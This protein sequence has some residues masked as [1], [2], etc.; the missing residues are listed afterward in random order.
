MIITFALPGHL[1]SRQ[2]TNTYAIYDQ[3]VKVL[4]LLAQND[5]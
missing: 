2:M 5:R 4:I 1:Q 3:P